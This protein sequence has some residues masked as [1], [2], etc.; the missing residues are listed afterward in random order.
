MPG[1]SIDLKV[2]LAV[3]RRSLLHLDGD[4]RVVADM[5][6]QPGKGIEQ[7]GLPGVRVANE[8]HCQRAS[9]HV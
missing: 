4:A 1:R 8:C 5:L 3:P 7:R 6:A 9:H 2:D